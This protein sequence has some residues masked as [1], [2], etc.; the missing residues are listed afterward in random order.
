MEKYISPEMEILTVDK[1]TDVITNSTNQDG[2]DD[3]TIM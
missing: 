1:S 2:F 3:S